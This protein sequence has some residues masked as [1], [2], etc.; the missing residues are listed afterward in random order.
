MSTKPIH[1][2]H[3][4]IDFTVK[5]TKEYWLCMCKQS[6][7]RPFCDGSHLH[8]DIQ[9]LRLWEIFCCQLLS[10]VHLNKLIF[11]YFSDGYW[12]CIFICSLIFFVHHR[13]V[14]WYLCTKITWTCIAKNELQS[15]IFSL[16]TFCILM[17]HLEFLGPLR[18]NNFFKSFEKIVPNSSNIPALVAC[19][20]L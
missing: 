1:I 9:D 12:I 14:I 8:P 15:Q 17:K 10:Q 13:W 11:W 3:R 2:K 7:K 6:D 18:G 20:C 4:P 16:D 5:E 19:W